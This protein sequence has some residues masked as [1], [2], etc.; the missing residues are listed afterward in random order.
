MTYTHLV[1]DI[2]FVSVTLFIYIHK[3]ILTINYPGNTISIITSFAIVY[4]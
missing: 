1:C 4:L 2:M 3:N